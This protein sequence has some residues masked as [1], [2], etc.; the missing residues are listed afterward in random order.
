M[1]IARLHS[2]HTN[3]LKVINKITMVLHYIRFTDLDIPRTVVVLVLAI[4]PSSTA[5]IHLIRPS[6]V[7]TSS[8]ISSAE[9]PVDSVR[10]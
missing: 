10:C 6:G 2:F 4:E 3:T 7:T 1:C 8:S 5:A 9:Y